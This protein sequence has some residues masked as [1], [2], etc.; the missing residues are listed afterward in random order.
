[1]VLSGK[2]KQSKVPYLL[3]TGGAY[4]DSSNVNSASVKKY[5]YRPTCS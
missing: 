5:L 1:M 2:T 4:I 3:K